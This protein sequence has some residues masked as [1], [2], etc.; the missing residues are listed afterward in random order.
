MEEREHLIGADI[1]TKV[2]KEA[3]TKVD[4]CVFNE[5]NVATP[6]TVRGYTLFLAHD[7]RPFRGTAIYVHVKWAQPVEKVPDTDAEMD[8]EVFH[9]QIRTLPTL[10]T[11]IVIPQCNMRPKFK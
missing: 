1:I 5:L 4:F 9:L 6:P 11:L 7:D 8:L 2:C 10:H 3:T